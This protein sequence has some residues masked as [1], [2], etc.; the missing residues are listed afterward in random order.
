MPAESPEAIPRAREVCNGESL[1]Y[2]VKKTGRLRMPRTSRNG[3]HERMTRDAEIAL[4]RAAAQPNRRIQP[5]A[6]GA[7]LSR[8]G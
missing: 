4:V 2:S 3:V 7:I 8:R 5:A 6:A 1:R